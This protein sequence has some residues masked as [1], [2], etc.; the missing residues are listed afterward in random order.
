MRWTNLE[1]IIQCEVSQKKKYKYH[2]LTHIYGIQE[3]TDEFICRAAME[4]QNR[5]M[6]M[7]GGKEGEVRCMERVTWKPTI[8]FVKQI[9]SGNLYYSGNTNR[10]SATNLEGWDGEG[11][12]KE[13]RE[14]EDMGVPMT[15]SC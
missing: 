13:V 1:P 5:F 15:D 7:G 12:G 8:P 11:D 10:G 9:A 14:G 4:K 6:D 3:C 2:I